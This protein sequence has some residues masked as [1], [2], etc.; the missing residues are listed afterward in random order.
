MASQSTSSNPEFCLCQLPGRYL[1]TEG[2]V[3][4]EHRLIGT[5]G[6][7]KRHALLALLFLADYVVGGFESRVFLPN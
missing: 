7:K 2:P 6:S 4:A 3:F 1:V 5:T